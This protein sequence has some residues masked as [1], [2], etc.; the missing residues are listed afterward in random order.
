MNILLQCA[1]A[2]ICGVLYHT[3]IKA[4]SVKKRFKAANQ[5]FVIS[6][7]LRDE[8]LAIAS[9]VITVVLCLVVID[10]LFRISPRVADYIKALFAF[11]GYT[12]ASIIQ[13]V[14]GKSEKY[15]LNI[16]DKKTNIADNK[17][18]ADEKTEP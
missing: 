5:E 1:I 11:M 15:I 3:I 16:I 7:F 8:A 13:H 18:G 4:Q 14:F 10:E 2:G 12:G 6:K 9:S 17:T